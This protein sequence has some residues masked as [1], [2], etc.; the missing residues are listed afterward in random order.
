MIDAKLVEA[1]YLTITAEDGSFAASA[2]L[3]AVA[4]AALT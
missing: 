1:T 3:E 2:P 4:D